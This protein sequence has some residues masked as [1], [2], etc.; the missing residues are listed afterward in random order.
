MCRNYNIFHE[1]LVIIASITYSKYNYSRYEP[2]L[3]DL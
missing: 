3:Y 1:Q 2:Y